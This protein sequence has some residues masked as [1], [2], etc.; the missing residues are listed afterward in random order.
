MIPV[1]IP[2]IY[3]N[4]IGGGYVKIGKSIKPNDRRKK[5]SLLLTEEP[6]P[7]LIIPGP[8]KLEGLVKKLFKKHKCKKGGT[9]VYHEDPI[10]AFLQDPQ[11]HQV[12]YALMAKAYELQPSPKFNGHRIPNSQREEVIK[13]I[14]AVIGSDAWAIESELNKKVESHFGKFIDISTFVSHSCRRRMA[15]VGLYRGY[16]NLTGKK[17]KE[18]QPGYKSAWIRQ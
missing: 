16:I 13:F 14:N 18:R 10:I 5:T 11:C 15:E 9:E 12:L 7:I 1:T 8:P 6:E 2:S 4:R 17:S 3:I